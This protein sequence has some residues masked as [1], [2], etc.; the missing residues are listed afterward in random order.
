MSIFKDNK[1]L[2][3]SQICNIRNESRHIEPQQ[4]NQEHS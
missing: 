3:N 2:N 1:S 4:D